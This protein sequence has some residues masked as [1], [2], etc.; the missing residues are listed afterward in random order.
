MIEPRQI[1][2][3]KAKYLKKKINHTKIRPYPQRAHQITAMSNSATEL[4]TLQ[5]IYCECTDTS[6]GR[7][8]TMG[9]LELEPD[10]TRWEFRRQDRW[11]S[12]TM[13]RDLCS[14]LLDLPIEMTSSSLGCMWASVQ[15]SRGMGPDWPGNPH[16]PAVETWREGEGADMNSPATG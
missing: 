6:G 11:P 7:A 8:V 9:I 16:T 10:Q 1:T 5:T 3:R 14:R 2:R 13:G 12:T 4:S 15:L